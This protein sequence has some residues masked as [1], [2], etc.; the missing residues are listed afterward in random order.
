MQ[1][2]PPERARVITSLFPGHHGLPGRL[3]WREHPSCRRRWS[4]GPSAFSS[5]I[6]AGGRS[7]SGASTESGPRSAR[8]T[9]HDSAGHRFRRH[10]NP[11]NR[12]LGRFGHQGIAAAGHQGRRYLVPVLVRAGRRCP[13]KGG[14]GPGFG[15]RSGIRGALERWTRHRRAACEPL[16]RG[17]EDRGVGD[18]ARVDLPNYQRPG[19]AGGRD[20]G[21][22]GWSD[23]ME[24]HRSNR[25]QGLLIY[26]PGRGVDA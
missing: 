14:L 24:L 12:A 23:R 17:A 8:Q 6:S 5:P 4:G 21:P 7:R 18:L 13:A 2:H 26:L 9:A 10:R 15:H 22:G 11:P 19:P 16:R 1:S 3:R 20:H 25:H